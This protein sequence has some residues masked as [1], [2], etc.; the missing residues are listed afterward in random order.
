[1]G[2]DTQCIGLQPMGVPHG[3][4]L[5]M[6]RRSIGTD[7]TRKPADT[8]DISTPPVMTPVTDMTEDKDDHFTWVKK[9]SPWHGSVAENCRV[10][11]TCC[12]S[13]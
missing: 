4:H 12:A 13:V 11:I 10:G 5:G 9:E 6:Y 2:M 1:M 3:P 8:C 7:R